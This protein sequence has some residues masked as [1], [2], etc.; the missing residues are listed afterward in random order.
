MLDNLQFPADKRLIDL[1][2]GEL[3]MGLNQDVLA[4]ALKNV[5]PV[6]ITDVDV[7]PDTG[8]PEGPDEY[9]DNERA[10]E[11][12]RTKGNP[13]SKASLA[14]YRQRPYKDRFGLNVGG[15]GLPYEV[16]GKRCMYKVSDL[17]AI[18]S[19]LHYFVNNPPK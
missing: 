18:R 16:R 1:T 15:Y 8:L 5:K 19:D 17:L 12:I 14:K 2:Y 3:V 7:H 6:T 11:I 4:E 9:V 10:I 13:L